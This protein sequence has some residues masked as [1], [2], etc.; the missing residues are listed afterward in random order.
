MRTSPK[1]QEITPEYV[2]APRKGVVV[3]IPFENITHFS[4]SDK[5]ASAHTTSGELLLNVSLDEL[6]EIFG[7]LVVRTHRSWLAVK[8]RLISVTR[9]AAIGG[10]TAVVQSPMNPNDHF[11]LRVS[12]RQ[13]PWVRR[14]LLERGVQCA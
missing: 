1:S 10:A 14:A 8:A 3:R 2:Q 12:R 7:A 13:V 11:K 9:D 4:F 5:Y 6:E